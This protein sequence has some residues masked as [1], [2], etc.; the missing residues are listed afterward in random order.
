M[1][2]KLADECKQHIWE[3]LGIKELCRV[4]CVARRSEKGRHA[5][6]VGIVAEA[7]RESFKADWLVVMQAA[8]S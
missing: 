5:R 2:L 8:T 4:A 6:T 1:L 3:F 7:I